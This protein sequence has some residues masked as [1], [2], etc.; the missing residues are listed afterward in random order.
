M[1]I[2]MKY[3]FRRLLAGIVITPVVACLWVVLIALM[4][5][6]GAEPSLSV[7][8]YFYHGLVIGTIASLW[9]AISAYG[10]GN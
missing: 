3:V 8:E 4:V 2:K 9:F 7:R 1:E 6:W 10:K 5:A